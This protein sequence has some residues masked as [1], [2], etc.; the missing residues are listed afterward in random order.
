MGSCSIDESW[1]PS[2]A[3]VWEGA[4]LECTARARMSLLRKEA[5][6]RERASRRMAAAAGTRDWVSLHRP[7][8]RAASADA[9]RTGTWSDA[10]RTSGRTNHQN[11]AKTTLA[12]RERVAKAGT[13]LRRCVPPPCGIPERRSWLVRRP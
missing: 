11:A 6:V 3:G 9:I 12:L 10:A 4:D 7:A 2:K 5:A 1:R 8:T 13:P